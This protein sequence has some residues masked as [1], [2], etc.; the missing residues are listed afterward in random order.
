MDNQEG[1]RVMPREG[2]PKG[3]KIALIALIII[4]A[5]LCAGYGGLCFYASSSGKLLPNTTAAGVSV[6]GMTRAEAETAL[7]SAL[8]DLPLPAHSAVLGEISLT[9][10][11][12]PAN[13]LEKRLQE[14]ARLGFSQ[15]IL[16]P[17]DPL[18]SIPGIKFT[19]VSHIREAILLLRG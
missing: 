5:A 1:K 9:G 3:K 13:R 6:G 14:C 10:Q 7:A 17:M 16:P 11:I 2:G 18:P 4:L 15:A 12:R 19:F 8:S